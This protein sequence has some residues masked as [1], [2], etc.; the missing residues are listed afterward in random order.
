M[1]KDK[2]VGFLTLGC[3]VNTYESDA[4]ASLFSSKGYQVVDGAEG[5]DICIV[6]TCTVTNLSDRK[7][8][9]ALRKVKKDNPDA[10]VVA[11]GCYV[12][13]AWDEVKD[14]QEVDVLIGN[15]QKSSV[16][17]IVES[18]I[19]SNGS[20]EWVESNNLDEYDNLRMDKPATTRAFIKVQDGCRQFCSYCIIPYA[21]GPLRSRALDDIVEE[22]IHLTENGVRE[23]VISGIHVASYGVDLKEVDWI[24]LVE[25]VARETPIKRIRLSSME[26]GGITMDG[27]KRLAA[28]GKLCDHF[29]LSLQSGSDSILKRMNRKYTSDEFLNKMDMIR[30]V[31][32]NAGLTTDIIV[33]F[34]GETE[35]NFNET[36]EFVKRAKFSRLHVFPFSPRKGTP[37]AKMS[38]QVSG[39]VKKLRSRILTEVGDI[40]EEQFIEDRLGLKVKVLPEELLGNNTVIGYSENYI[41]CKISSEKTIDGEVISGVIVGREGQLA[42]CNREG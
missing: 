16:V 9:Q 7:S 24:D 17:E 20:Q 26:A 22:I 32:P 25:V 37:A 6:N 38:E 2:T 11:A 18:Y 40:L 4:M 14:I 3:K 33:G 31:F 41:R 5:A 15:A 1:S 23:V 36:L 42:L 8:R 30:S 10:V 34:P 12:Q 28:T 13:V 29:H 21:R 27:L 35:K 19:D 39:P